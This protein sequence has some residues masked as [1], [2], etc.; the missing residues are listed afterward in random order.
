MRKSMGFNLSAPGRGDLLVRSRLRV[1]KVP[2]SKHNSNEDPTYVGLLHIKSDLEVQTYSRWCGTEVWRGDASSSVFLIVCVTV[3][4]NCEVRPKRT[5]A[6]LQN[7]A[8]I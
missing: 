7:G 5:L 4:Q 6:F 8:L 2:G 1:Q 3:V